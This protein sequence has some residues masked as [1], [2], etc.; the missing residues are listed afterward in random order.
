M[1][2]FTS[3]FEPEVFQ[4][5]GMAATGIDGSYNTDGGYSQYTAAADVEPNYHS[6]PFMATNDQGMG[7][8]QG[9]N[10]QTPSY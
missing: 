2:Q 6:N 4:Q 1:T 10:F 8:P 3:G 7:V 5:Q 9:T